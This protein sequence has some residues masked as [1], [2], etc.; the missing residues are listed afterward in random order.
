MATRRSNGEGGP[1]WNKARQRWVSS[2]LRKVSH[3]ET[4]GQ[5]R[6]SAA[7]TSAEVL[8]MDGFALPAEFNI[9][10]ERA[11]EVTV[12]LDFQSGLVKRVALE[13]TG[14]HPEVVASDVRGLPLLEFRDEAV[15]RL[16]KPVTKGGKMVLIVEDNERR[17][18]G[19]HTYNRHR[20]RVNSASLARVAELAHQFPK[21]PGDLRTIS[22]R[23]YEAI[24]EEFE[25]DTR[26]A[27]LWVK[28]ASDRGLL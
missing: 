28:R 26:S 17:I 11:G 16:M 4:W 19:K 10:F 25:V 24:R 15:K 6:T 21:E 8:T 3:S 20:R 5:M 23:A 14:D 9:V 2:S 12:R 7:I 22:A 1:S 13:A 18:A 27:Q